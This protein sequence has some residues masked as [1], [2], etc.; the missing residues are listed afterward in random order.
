LHK[1]A[2]HDQLQKIVSKDAVR[3]RSHVKQLLKRVGHDTAGQQVGQALL[4]LL[5]APASAA[6]HVSTTSTAAA[7]HITE[8]Q[9]LV[10]AVGAKHLLR[11][12]SPALVQA[13]VDAQLVSIVAALQQACRKDPG[14][15]LQLLE[16]NL[17]G[18]DKY[19]AEQVSTM[20]FCAGELL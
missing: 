14:T 18:L 1:A 5:A 11:F 19:T 17:A 9:Q 2:Q 6:V 4:Q 13:A 16:Q 7:D 10:A 12:G 8:V 20:A 3:L 15:F